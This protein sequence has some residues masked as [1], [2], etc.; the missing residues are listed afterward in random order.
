MGFS[1]D[2]KILQTST[3]IIRAKCKKVN[4]IS[5]FSAKE[6]LIFLQH[7]LNYF[8]KFNDLVSII[9]GVD[10]TK[11]FCIGYVN[12]IH[13]PSPWEFGQGDKGDGNGTKFLI[14]FIPP[15]VATDGIFKLFKKLFL[16]LVMSSR[17]ARNF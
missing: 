1:K 16:C 11:V 3:F 8:C 5:I 13:I 2:I 17:S 7:I 6:I 15:I 14:K 4:R 10:H 9:V 12:I